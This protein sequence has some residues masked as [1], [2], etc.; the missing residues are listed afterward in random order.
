MAR[1]IVE[2]VYA[3]MGALA[4]VTLM[5]DGVKRGR[6]KSGATITINTDAGAHVL[7]AHLWWQ[8]SN[9]L[10]LVLEDDDVVTVELTTSQNPDDPADMSFL[11][12]LFHPGAAFTLRLK[13]E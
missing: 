7:R 6:V 2:R 4:S 5:L 10:S 9:P 11:R 13:N 3:T 12:N 1:I 8:A